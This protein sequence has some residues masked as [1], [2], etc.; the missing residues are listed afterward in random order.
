MGNSR[1]FILIVATLV[2]L[3]AHA[4]DSVD[5]EMHSRVI[6]RVQSDHQADMKSG[7]VRRAPANLRNN[8]P[9]A[10]HTDAVAAKHPT[11]VQQMKILKAAP[12][13]KAKTPVTK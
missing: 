13:V 3:S 8:A 2:P 5:S 7:K 12:V 11:Q 4:L 6:Q 9:S 10:I 1:L